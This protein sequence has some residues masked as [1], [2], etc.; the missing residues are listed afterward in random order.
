VDLPIITRKKRLKNPLTVYILHIYDLIDIRAKKRMKSG[1]KL[2][3]QKEIELINEL[4]CALTDI[5]IN[6]KATEQKTKFGVLIK[7]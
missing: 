3:F 6:S 2:N 5:Y 4:E 7:N 1:P